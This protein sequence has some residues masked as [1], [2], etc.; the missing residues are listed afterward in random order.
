MSLTLP[1]T[2]RS[3][4]RAA[5]L[6]PAAFAARAQQNPSWQA[7]CQAYLEKAGKARSAPAQALHAEEAKLALGG[8]ID[9]AVFNSV[10]EFIPRAATWSISP[11]P[12]SSGS[13]ACM[14]L[15]RASHL[16]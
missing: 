7:R 8:P 14:D 3:L 5:A 2:R 6:A 9:P 10:L 4:L 16:T 1:P 15:T 13:C 11:W 12:V